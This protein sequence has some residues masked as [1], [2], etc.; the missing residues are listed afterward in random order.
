MLEIGSLEWLTQ[1]IH[2][3]SIYRNA[4]IN[5][6]L[7]SSVDFIFIIIIIFSLFNLIILFFYN[8]GIPKYTAYHKNIKLFAIL[9]TTASSVV[10]LC[11]IVYCFFYLMNILTPIENFYLFATKLTFATFVGCKPIIFGYERSIAIK[12]ALIYDKAGMN[13]IYIII[14]VFIPN[15]IPFVIM[16]VQNICA[17]IYFQKLKHILNKQWNE[18]IK[19]KTSLSYR[20]Q[21]TENVK[22]FNIVQVV[23]LGVSCVVMSA[24]PLFILADSH[25]FDINI[26]SIFFDVSSTF[27]T[28]FLLVFFG[29]LH[30]QML[31]KIFCLYKLNVPRKSL[32]V[33]SIRE[34]NNKN[35]EIYF[36]QMRLEWNKYNLIA[37]I[38][39]KSMHSSV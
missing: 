34:I 9:I 14:S 13:Y 26:A 21:L 35:T 16:G 31:K 25:F 4:I 2:S 33:S 3:T 1:N 7:D 29:V 37:L 18:E 23:L 12:N 24:I 15:Y 22:T 11:H 20:F 36:N 17:L 5:K 30:T 10:T 8:F 6:K 19:N 39:E 28:T 32:T 38:L 27:I